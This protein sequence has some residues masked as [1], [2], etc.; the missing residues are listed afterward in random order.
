M[1]AAL[2]DLGVLPQSDLS[3]LYPYVP[4]VTGLESDLSPLTS[5]ATAATDAAES[6]SALTSD[7]STSNLADVS[8]SLIA[9]AT[10]MASLFANSVGSL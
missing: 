5:D 7:L 3:D 1:I 4:D 10:D 6:L 8:S 9:A 2:V